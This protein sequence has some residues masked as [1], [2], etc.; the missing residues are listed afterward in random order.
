[1]R[2]AASLA[3]D[4][5][6]VGSRGSDLLLARGMNQPLLAA[7]G[8]PVNCGYDGTPSHCIESN[9]AVNARL[10]V[11]IMGETPTALTISEFAGSSWYHSM[12]ATL[13]KQ[14]SRGLSRTAL[15]PREDASAAGGLRLK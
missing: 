14:M 4:I 15:Y 8:S 13:R 2:L 5:G 10:R 3:V 9:T 7:A 11:P 1:M 12:Q 6:Y